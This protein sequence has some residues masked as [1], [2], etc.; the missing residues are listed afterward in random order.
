MMRSLVAPGG[1]VLAAA[2]CAAQQPIPIPDEFDAAFVQGTVCMP[3]DAHTGDGVVDASMPCTVDEDCAADLECRGKN[4]DDSKYCTEPGVPITF[5]T[6]IY[7]CV[8]LEPATVEFRWF[9]SC[10]GGQCTIVPLLTAHVVRVENESDCDGRW[11]EDPP[12]DECFDEHFAF[13]MTPPVNEDDEWVHATYTVDLPYLD[14]DAAE[15]VLDRLEAG[16]ST[17]DALEPEIANVRYPERQFDVTFAPGN[18][19]AD[20]TSLSG[21]DCT[22][23]PAP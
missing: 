8:K 19:I 9:W 21:A 12:D 7:R 4:E 13:G 6:C 14:M 23:I 3:R 2:G 20:E 16:D 15:R 10:A 18:P 22:E 1:L 17:S 11:L 5:D